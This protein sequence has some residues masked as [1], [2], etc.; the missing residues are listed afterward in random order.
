MAGCSHTQQCFQKVMAW[1]NRDVS[2]PKPCP[3]P[4]VGATNPWDASGDE[5]CTD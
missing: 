5:R 2:F 4:M 3:N 1:T